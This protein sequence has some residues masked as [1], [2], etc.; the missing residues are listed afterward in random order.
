MFA[1]FSASRWHGGRAVW[2]RRGYGG[3]AVWQRRGKLCPF[4]HFGKIMGLFI[5]VNPAF[6]S[7]LAWGGGGH[8]QQGWGEYQIYEYEYKYE[9]L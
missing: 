3:R 2:Q 1:L 7:F 9:S 4:G 8:N 5:H 6:F